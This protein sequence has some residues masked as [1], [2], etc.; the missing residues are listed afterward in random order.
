MHRGTG[1]SV[2]ARRAGG[3]GGQ[4]TTAAAAEAV[5]I[6]EGSLAPLLPLGPAVLEP[7]LNEAGRTKE[8]LRKRGKQKRM[9]ND[10]IVSVLV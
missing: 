4:R 10:N 2:Q 7:D 1:R 8:K 9:H 5:G 6:F 3:G